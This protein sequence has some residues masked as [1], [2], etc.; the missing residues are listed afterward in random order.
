VDGLTRQSATN[1]NPQTGQVIS[2]SPSAEFSLSGVASDVEHEFCDVLEQLCGTAYVP[3]SPDEI[4][5]CVVTGAGYPPVDNSGFVANFVRKYPGALVEI[6]MQCFHPDNLPVLNTLA[7]E[8]VICDCWF[9][10]HPGPTWP[11]RFF[12]HAA[13]PSD[14]GQ[15]DSPPDGDIVLAFTKANRYHFKN[16][17]IYDRLAES[18][19]KHKI[20]EGNKCPQVKGIGP[21]HAALNIG[22]FARFEQELQ[23]PGFDY[24][25]VFIEP[26]NGTHGINIVCESQLQNDMHPPTDVRLGEA[27]VKRV[28]EAIRNSPV[29]NQSALLVTFD[30]HGGFFDHVPPPRAVPPGDGAI[31][32]THNF[33]WD[34][35]GVRVPALIVSPWV[36]RNVVDHNQYDH[37]SIL[38]SVEKLFGLAGLTQRD[39]AAND[40]LEVFSQITPRTDAPTTLPSP[41]ATPPITSKPPGSITP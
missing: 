4:D 18:G 6:P 5:D 29:W 19:L 22:S 37:S 28:Y 30:E 40:F 32:R 38:A 24:S 23:D 1:V 25:Y 41:P 39:A 16:G 36:G 26:D 12:I 34:Q 7:N 33:R 8:F 3:R 20:Y 14:E 31:D 17:T 10:S 27:L 9:A 21:N 13:S 15:V 2:T 35:L 11:N